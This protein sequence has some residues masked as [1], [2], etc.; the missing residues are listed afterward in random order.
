MTRAHDNSLHSGASRSPWL[1]LALS[2]LG[3]I[4]GGDVLGPAPTAPP[5]DTAMDLAVGRSHACTVLD[6]T[7]ECWGRNDQG[8]VS[9][10]RGSD[11][12]TPEPVMFSGR[13]KLVAAGEAHTCALDDLG[14]VLCWG[15]NARGQLGVGDRADRE[16]PT[17]VPLPARAS[18]LSTHFRHSCALLI[19]G[20][21]ACWGENREGQLGQGDAF[22]VDDPTAADALVP[23]V[24]PGIWRAVSTGDGHTCAVALD[25]KLWCW[26]R[27]SEHELGGD[28]RIQ[29]RTPLEVEP[30]TEWLGVSAGQNY[31]CGVQTDQSLWCWGQN[32]DDGPLGIPGAIE[33][34]V[35]TRVSASNGW[36]R[37][38][39]NA[40]HTCALNTASELWCW[41]RNVE[42]QLGNGDTVS[43][44]L[45]TGDD[46]RRSEFTLVAR[47]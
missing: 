19:D 25:G 16:A 5:V 12:W 34:A 47:P 20:R 44:Q 11:Q 37:V 15:G 46:A 24:V 32:I 10:T 42:G 38:E 36:T 14:G 18:A 17:L 31:T 39:A 30:G 28:T 8:Q 7:V 21:L 22:P 26:G 3:C 6:G 2:A 41:G 40:L 35:P 1:A 13:W 33:L 23:I 29:V 27:N 45:G 4:E 43:R 9:S